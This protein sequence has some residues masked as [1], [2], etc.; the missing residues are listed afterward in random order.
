MSTYEKA[1]KEGKYV[2]YWSEQFSELTGIQPADDRSYG[3]PINQE[4]N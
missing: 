4:Q 2:G 1:K 3:E